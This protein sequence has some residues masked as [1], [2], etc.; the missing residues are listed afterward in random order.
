MQGTDVLHTLVKWVAEKKKKRKS[1][2]TQRKTAFELWK[3]LSSASFPIA[4]SF[5]LKVGL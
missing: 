2:P 4:V 3:V 1:P 5:F